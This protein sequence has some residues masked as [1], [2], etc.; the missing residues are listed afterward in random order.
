[1]RAYIILHNM[2]IED[3]RHG[4]THFDVSKFVQA[5]SARSS[6]VDFTDMP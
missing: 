2:I 1:M 4:Y 3:E 6:L 5:K